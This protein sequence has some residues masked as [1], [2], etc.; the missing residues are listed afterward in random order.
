MKHNGSKFFPDGAIPRFYFSL[1]PEPVL[2]AAGHVDMDPTMLLVLLLALADVTLIYAA[3]LRKGATSMKLQWNA[4]EARRFAEEE[5][6][7]AVAE[8]KSE[9]RTN[10]ILGMIREHLP[11]ASIERP[12][13][14]LT[15]RIGEAVPI[16]WAKA[17]DFQPW[18]EQML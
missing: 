16:G 9:E 15:P 12:Y 10:M 5:K 13:E 17:G 8:A 1:H 18:W 14:L 4:D 11:L 7:E 6:N 2:N 3:L